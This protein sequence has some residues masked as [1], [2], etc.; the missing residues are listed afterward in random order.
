MS[1]KL[2][3]KNLRAKG[4]KIIVDILLMSIFTSLCLLFTW[5]RSFDV[6]QFWSMKKKQVDQLFS[7]TASTFLCWM[8]RWSKLSG[9]HKV[10]YTQLRYACPV[11]LMHGASLVCSKLIF[12]EHTTSHGWCENGANLIFNAEIRCAV[13]KHKFKCKNTSKLHPIFPLC[14]CKNRQT[15]V[16]HMQL[17]QQHCLC[18]WFSPNRLAFSKNMFVACVLAA[19][20]M[21]SV[22]M[23]TSLKI[24]MYWSICVK[25]SYSSFFFLFFFLYTIVTFFNYLL[26]NMR[27]IIS[28]NFKSK[29]KLNLRSYL[30]STIT[31]YCWFKQPFVKRY[32]LSNLKN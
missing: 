18:S 25:C 27:S 9:Y 7:K 2:L 31:T 14:S 22:P 19:Q 1:R 13:R 6:D 20:C 24:F 16:C 4:W 5:H 29:K 8:F 28:L 26:W 12:C 21:H 17:Q 15:L 23:G 32:F 30:F 10:Q 11:P 3:W